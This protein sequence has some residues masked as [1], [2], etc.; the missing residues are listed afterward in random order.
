MVKNQTAAVQVTVEVQIG[1]S[2]QPSGLQ[3]LE[4]PQVWYSSAQ[5]QS[6]ARG[7]SICCGCGHKKKLNFMACELYLNKAVIKKQTRLQTSEMCDIDA[8]AT[9]FVLIRL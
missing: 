1:S 8:H 4:M 6:P 7:V 3:G 2:A 5:I 9:S